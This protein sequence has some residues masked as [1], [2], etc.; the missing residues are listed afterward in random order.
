MTRFSHLVA[1]GLALSE[2]TA[3]GAAPSPPPAQ[4]ANPAAPH[5]NLQ[6]IV[7]RYWDERAVRG[8]PPS[9][10]FMADSLAVERRYLD[11]VLAIPRAQ[12]DAEGG[13][14]YD[15]FKRQRELNIEGFTYPT[16]LMPVNPF[17]GM[18]LQFARAAADTEQRPF[19][20]AKDYDSWLL[21]IDGYT[22]WSK[23]AIANM[24]EGMRR[25]YTSPRVLMER[26]LP[27]LQGL[28]EDT[29]ANV[30]YAPLRT[31]P[32]AIKEPERTRLSASVTA[33][34]KDQLLPAYRE[35]HDFI[36]REY[37]PRARASIALSALPLGPSWYAFRVKRATGS[38]LTPT[39]IHAIG[40]AEVERI[41]ARMPAQPA[42]PPPQPKTEPLSDYLE[43]K[44]QTLAALPALFS[45]TPRTD[46]E[47][48]PLGRMGDAA[49]LLVHRPAAPE[50]GAPAI[51]YVNTD[52]SAARPAGAQIPVF[53][54]EALPG[55]HYQS[56]LQQE[57]TDLPRFR[58]FGV[59]PAFADGWALYAASLGDELGLYR[60]EEAKRSAA[61]AQLKCAVALVADTGIHAQ[62][63]TRAQAADY[64][65][66]QLGVDPAEAGLVT[67]RFVA[68]P[69]D[70]LA[71]K[72]GE[73]KFQA[74]RARAQQ[75][76]SQR[77]D[78]REFHT[79]ILKDGAMPLDI[80]E[81]KMKR[82]M[83]TR[84]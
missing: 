50:E 74:L 3:C 2:L 23:Q 4:A 81:A 64:V 66:A 9:A 49:T 51:L 40:T 29:S 18:P 42:G 7:D 46:F 58:R 17:D 53:L 78:I 79:E 14:T 33:A 43:L 68:L 11:E 16:E 44:V 73:L 25:G 47:I 48:R 69:G 37:L 62:D 22:A 21:R 32:E 31:M 75:T 5:D 59:E 72:M 57:R 82:W 12:L 60:D 63:W 41:R 45:A 61:L 27:L 67:D 83:E 34:V 77:F 76:L 30:F 70:A 39:E 24:R 28:G 20:T 19:K 65:R 10:Q 26:M 71:C 38:Q 80:L 56:A 8:N 36:Q 35:L 13:L 52:P 6:Q 55:R 15:I 84:R 54:Q 1:L